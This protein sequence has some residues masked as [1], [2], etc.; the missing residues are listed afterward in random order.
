MAFVESSI[1]EDHAANSF[2]HPYD[3]MSNNIIQN[4]DVYGYFLDEYHEGQ[5]KRSLGIGAYSNSEVEISINK[6]NEAF[7]HFNEN[8]N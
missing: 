6:L 4:E 2:S 7:N 8:N 3:N 5:A 1:N